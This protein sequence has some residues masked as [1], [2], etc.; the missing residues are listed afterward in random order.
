V[1][2]AGEQEDAVGA[3]AAVIAWRKHLMTA[4]SCPAA[5]KQALAV[6]VLLY[7]LGMALAIDAVASGP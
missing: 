5:A 1:A 6:V 2:G 3:E 4:G 7:P